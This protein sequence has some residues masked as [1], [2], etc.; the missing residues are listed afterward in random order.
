MLTNGFTYGEKPFIIEPPTN[1]TTAYRTG[2]EFAVVAG[3]TGPLTYQWQH[4][5]VNLAD[6][7]VIPGPRAT[8]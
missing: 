7:G 3:G 8:S 6:G 4:N 1:Q 2:V 5:G